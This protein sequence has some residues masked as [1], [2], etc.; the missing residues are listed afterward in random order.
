MGSLFESRSDE[1]LLRTYLRGSYRRETITV[2]IV[3]III[4]KVCQGG[5]TPFLEKY[6]PLASWVDHNTPI[7]KCIQQTEQ[8]P[9]C[10]MSNDEHDRKEGL[11]GKARNRTQPSLVSNQQAELRSNHKR[12]LYHRNKARY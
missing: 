12:S 4:V 1:R 5:I 7:R 2:M 3:S 6:L 10:H 9:V 11:Q 8:F